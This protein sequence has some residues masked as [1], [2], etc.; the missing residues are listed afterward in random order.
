MGAVGLLLLFL[1][2]FNLLSSSDLNNNEFNYLQRND[3]RIYFCMN[4]YQLNQ[5]FIL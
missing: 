2:L 5:H 4:K 1:F 3:V